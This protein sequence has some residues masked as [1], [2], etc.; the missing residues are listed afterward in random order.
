MEKGCTGNNLFC[1][2]YFLWDDMPGHTG[3]YGG[4]M[5]EHFS[6]VLSSLYSE[7]WWNG[8]LVEVQ[9]PRGGGVSGGMA[10]V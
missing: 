3:G 7:I 6:F 9:Y 2:F 1:P 10:E 5:F 4:V 8:L